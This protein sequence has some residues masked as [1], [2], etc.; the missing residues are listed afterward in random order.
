[1]NKLMSM[2]EAQCTWCWV[3]AAALCGTA[4]LLLPAHTADKHAGACSV[5][6]SWVHP[7]A[8]CGAQAGPGGDG[9]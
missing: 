2:P 8:V 1:M 9:E 4:C 3:H 7:A 6:D 5:H